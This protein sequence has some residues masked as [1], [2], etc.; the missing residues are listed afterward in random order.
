MLQDTLVVSLVTNMEAQQQRAPSVN[1]ASV[2]PC[3][4]PSRA[5]SSTSSRVMKARRPG[6]GGMAKVQ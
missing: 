3:A 6:A 4:A 5:T 2:Q 1:N